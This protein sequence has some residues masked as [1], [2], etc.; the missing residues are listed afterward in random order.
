MSDRPAEPEAIADPRRD[1]LELLSDLDGLRTLLAQPGS[2]APTELGLGGVLIGPGACSSLPELAREL[3]PAGGEIAVLVDRRPMLGHGGGELKLWVREALSGNGRVRT[4]EIGGDDA[5]VHADPATLAT[6]VEKIG[7]ADLLV[8]VGSGTLSDIGKYASSRLHGLPHIVVQTAASVN[9]FADDQSV[10]VLEGV[11]RTTPTR[12]PDRLIIDTDVI[13]RAP[14]AMNRAGLGDLLASYT[15]P[16][17]WRLAAFM[18]QDDSFSPAIVALARDHVDPVLDHAAGVGSG[19]HRALELLSAGLTLSGIAMGAAGRTA[20]GSGMEHTASHLIE[21]A[22]GHGALHGAQVGILSVFAACL[23][24]VV[25]KAIRDGALA[26][27]R[28][29]D[30]REMQAR[31]TEAFSAAD[32]SGA[33]AAECWS[34]YRRKLERHNAGAAALA[35]ITERWPQLDAELARLLAPPR[36]LAA[37]LVGC[38]APTRLHELGIAPERAR[39]ALTNCH[40]MRDRFTV[41]DLAFLLGLWDDAGVEQVVTLAESFGCGL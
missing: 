16:A 21:M 38:G 10:L 4:V 25:R 14:V 19:D 34:D 23:W 13:T 39:W 15:A 17:D 29:P 30:E 41:A 28:F 22:D 32:P 1:G 31:V 9:G 26:A 18:G 3:M 33:M 6:A 37:A 20:P 24:Q 5:D 40:L 8:T 12:W 27:L 2:G 7:T 11:K 36:R 35:G